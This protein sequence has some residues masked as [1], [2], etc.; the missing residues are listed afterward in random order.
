MEVGDDDDAEG[1]NDD[2]D[3]YDDYNDD[4]DYAF[5]VWHE[6]VDEITLPNIITLGWIVK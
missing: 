6:S 1:D 2:V 3:D 5:A 4:D